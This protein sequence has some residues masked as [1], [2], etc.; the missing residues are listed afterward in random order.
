[1]F[2]RVAARKF[3]LTPQHAEQRYEFANIYGE[4]DED[5][6]SNVIF[7]DEKSFRQVILNYFWILTNLSLL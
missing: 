4:Y 3:S 2:A 7:C 6:W 1:M 5:W